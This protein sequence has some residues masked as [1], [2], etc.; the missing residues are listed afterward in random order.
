MYNDMDMHAK[1]FDHEQCYFVVPYYVP[2]FTTT[3]RLFSYYN[4]TI[5]VRPKTSAGNAPY[6]TT[7]AFTT[8]YM[9][10]K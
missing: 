5:N 4:Y 6:G 7:H 10:R 3:N 9:G 2:D 8:R 1:C